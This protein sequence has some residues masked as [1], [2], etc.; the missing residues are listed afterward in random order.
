M[1]LWWLM[2]FKGVSMS[3]LEGLREVLLGVLGVA[4]VAVVAV[5]E[6]V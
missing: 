6:V 3:L 1:S 2:S 4:E 5:E